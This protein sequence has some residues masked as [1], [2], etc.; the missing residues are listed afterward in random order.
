[1]ELQDQGRPARESAELPEGVRVYAIGDIHGHAALLDR[2]MAMILEDCKTWHD[3]GGR[4][5]L[6]CLGDYVDRGPDSRGVVE[7]LRQTPSFLEAVHLI[8][9]HDQ[10]LLDFLDDASV[11][12]FWLEFGGGATLLSYDVAP[13]KSNEPEAIAK[14]QSAL[15]SAI[16]EEHLQFF[17][18]LKTSFRIGG[19]YFVHAGVRPGVALEDQTPSDQLWIRREFLSSRA[20]FG[21]VIVHGH[22]PSAEPVIR[23]NRIG[24]DTGA[25]VTGKLTAL[26]LEAKTRRFLH[27]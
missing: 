23:D 21:A 25:Y 16:P 1:M 20:D 5:L 8:G 6:I 4:C 12:P 9:N 18:G 3:Q 11:Y 17:H 13:A 10:V 2:L 27:T 14:T 19:Y 26:V 24:I 7:R 22:T 15:R